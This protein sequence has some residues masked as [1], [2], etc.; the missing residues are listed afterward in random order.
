MPYESKAVF[1]LSY[2]YNQADNIKNTND[3]WVVELNVIFPLEI[4]SS[5]I[6]PCITTFSL[7]SDTYNVSTQAAFLPAPTSDLLLARSSSMKDNMDAGDLFSATLTVFTASANGSDTFNVNVRDVLSGLVYEALSAQF[8]EETAF[9]IADPADFVSE[10][11]FREFNSSDDY[12]IQYKLR[13]G[14]EIEANAQISAFAELHYQSGNIGALAKNVSLSTRI[15]T[16]TTAS[17]TYDFQVSTMLPETTEVAGV[18]QVTFGETA[19]ATFTITFTEGRTSG[20]QISV[21][22]SQ[23]TS[24]V[25][26]I[27]SLTVT[28]VGSKISS[29]E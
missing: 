20:S 26:E 4:T 17:P 16:A 14:S 24:A 5:N 10:L 11:P 18:H 25:V 8:S 28:H 2:I 9:L 7:T 22:A 3:E 6:Q 27:L 23:A 12:V 15:F 29:S 19:T 1:T 13:V 21:F